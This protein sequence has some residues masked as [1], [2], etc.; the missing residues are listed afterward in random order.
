MTPS[1]R[2]PTSPYEPTRHPDIE[3]HRASGVFY[4]RG[5]VGGHYITKSLR[6]KVWALAETRAK[7]LIAEAQGAPVGGR[8]GSLHRTFAEAFD[9]TLRIYE[10]K[11]VETYKQIKC[12][13]DG[14]LRPWFTAH[15]P[16]LRTFEADFELQWAKYRLHRKEVAPGVKLGHD[17]RFLITVLRRAQQKGWIKKV[18]EQKSLELM[19]ASEPIGRA[20][21]DE[22]V[23][24]LLEFL[25][26]RH[27]KT[28]LQALM[29]VTMGMRIA[30]ILHLRRD[31][32]DLFRKE[33]NLDAGRLKTRRR[34]KVPVPISDDVFPLLKSY[35]LAAKG[36]AVFPAE[37]IEGWEGAGGKNP[38][39][40]IVRVERDRPQ[41][42]NRYWWD[43][44]REATGVNCRFHDL[45]HTA[46][47]NA[48]AAQMPAT[49]AEKIFGA[50]PET[51]RRIYDH[52][53]PDA[54]KGFRGLFAGRF[55]TE[56]RDRKMIVKKGG[57]PRVSR[58]K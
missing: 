54:Q 53:M 32:V 46:I 56:G 1:R 58:G 2:R 40:K 39:R 50:T 27:E 17:R 20:L 31:E 34:R 10:P 19:E 29:A 36:T 6:T 4:F 28:Y 5:T 55:V 15:C 26:A 52:V 16:Y 3:R 45:R 14:R 7:N 49:T 35:V 23:R 30:E 12:I 18:P 13:I 43:R 47:T 41:D 51:I 57:K 38:G 8:F 44:A 21:E 25:R 24:A 37:H 48:L 9:L 11:G 22:E 42:D 33:I